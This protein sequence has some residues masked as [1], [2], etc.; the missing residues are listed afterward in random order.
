MNVYINNLVW[1]LNFLNFDFEFFL[2]NKLFYNI[3]FLNTS[4][5][6]KKSSQFFKIFF[7]FKFR[8]FKS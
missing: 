4:W 6:V 3:I 8:H 7:F 2:K 5:E 1:K